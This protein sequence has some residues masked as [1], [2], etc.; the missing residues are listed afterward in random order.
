MPGKASLAAQQYYA[1][2]RNAFWKIM[3]ELYGA[4]FDVAYEERLTL[5]RDNGIALWDVLH[6]CTRT[7]SLDSDI[8]S[9]SIVPNDVP[10]LLDDNPGI[11]RILFNGAKAEQVFERHMRRGKAG[12]V[13]RK[14]A[15][16]ARSAWCSPRFSDIETIRL[17]STSP[18]NAS[19]TFRQKFDAW[20]S[21]LEGDCPIAATG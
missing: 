11:G 20:R 6:S 13:P 5:L 18:A 16:R 3:G 19:K 1:H 12:T 7:S 21:A 4:G 2:P 9:D 8:V 14:G 17:P 10:G 15:W